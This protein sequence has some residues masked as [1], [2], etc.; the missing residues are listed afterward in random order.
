M[1]AFDTL[2]SDELRTLDALLEEYLDLADLDRNVWLSSACLQ[3]PRLADHLRTM[4]ATQSPE[5]TDTEAPSELRLS[6]DTQLGPWRICQWHASGGSC[7]VYRAERADGSFER[8]VAVKLLNQPGADW[9]TR[10]LREQHLLAKL[11]HPNIVSLLD[12]GRFKQ[13]AYLVMPWIQGQSLSEFAAATEDWRVRVTA[14]AQ[15]CDALAHAHQRLIIH[16]DLKPSNVIFVEGQAMVL[17]FGVAKLLDDDADPQATRNFFTPAYASPEQL[18]GTEI[19]VACDIHA[20]GLMLFE[21]LCRAPA[22]PKARNGLAYAV[23]AI[24]HQAAPAISGNPATHAIA[25]QSRNDLQSI[26][27]CAL[28]KAPSDRYGNAAQMAMDLRATLGG[29]AISIRKR[30]TWTNLRHWVGKNRL[31]SAAAA[32]ALGVAVL[33]FSSYVLQNQRI[34]A[35]RERALTQVKRL[36]S[37]REHFSL[38]LR[39]TALQGMG[40][41]AALDESIHNLSKLYQDQPQVRAEVLASLGELYVSAGD[42]LAARSALMPLVGNAA[43][44]SPL[45]ADIK[46]KALESLTTSELRLGENAAAADRLA[47]WQ[48]LL[49]PETASYAEWQLA[50]A[51]W[52]RQTGNADAALA[53]Q[54]QGVTAMETARDAAPI[55]QGIALANLGTSFFQLGQFSQAKLHYEKAVNHWSEYGLVRN[56][57]VRTV[58]TNLAHILFL[59]GEVEAA[60]ARY[61]PLQQELSQRGARSPSF[62]AL[63]IA[64]AR[65]EA[66]LGD[67]GIALTQISQARLIITETTGANGPD[68]LGAWLNEI[69]V[70]QQLTT[71]RQQ[72]PKT[73]YADQLSSALAAAELIARALPAAHPLRA[74]LAIAQARSLQLTGADEQAKTGYLDALQALTTAPAALLPMQWRARLYLAEIELA[75]GNRDQAKANVDAAMALVARLQTAEG[76]D[77]QDIR[78]W[79]R[80]LAGG[81]ENM[82]PER[83]PTEHPRR[84]ALA[85]CQSG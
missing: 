39:D 56:D 63:L 65:T 32:V 23:D 21:L 52:L 18:L 2:S 79:Q 38:I 81:R 6:A 49:E 5:G 60:R 9:Q 8:T 20:A 24:V 61:L 47:R 43:E 14:A 13:R 17:D 85:W 33:G 29:D 54:I 69:D 19:G 75:A 66:L 11:S 51:V 22:Y 74:R 28:A 41:R 44:F 76:L 59:Q 3:H 15:I 10:F 4:L 31:S 58:E 77:F 45:P 26:L 73:S 12:V 42:Y 71:M 25:R 80:C 55:A 40:A 72:D 1:S 27:D 53:L 37:L 70:L 67:A 82:L 83:L 7:D 68:A 35:E 64:L 34:A 46:R 50:R 62:A 57:N 78:A 48:T 30:S 16:R 36:E 84:I